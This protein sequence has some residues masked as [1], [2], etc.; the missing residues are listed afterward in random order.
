M[1]K[2]RVGVIG[3]SGIY[4][5]AQLRDVREVRLETPFGAPSDAYIVGHLDDQPVAF[6]P[7]HGRGHRISPSRLNSRANIYGFKMLGVSIWYRSA[8]AAACSCST[9]PA[10]LSCQTSP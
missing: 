2:V 5:L 9:G 8:H 6:L 3:G 7:R 10:I 4:D 1:E